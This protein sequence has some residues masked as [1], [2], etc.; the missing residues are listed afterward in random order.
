MKK[1]RP[2]ALPSVTTQMRTPC[3]KIYVT[4]TVDA[5]GLPFE[6]FVRF[7]KAGH[8]GAA[9]FDATT[10]L[11]SYALR[12]GMDP[13][14]AVKALGGI[15]CHCGTDSCMNAVSEGPK[16]ASACAP[17]AH[18]LKHPKLTQMP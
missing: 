3:G 15:G 13:I 2:A 5:D 16:P 18:V 10:R 12:S 14:E 4:V 1:P 9:I 17:I 7:G 8:C 11:I 6:T